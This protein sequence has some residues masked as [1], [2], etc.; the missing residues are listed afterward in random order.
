MRD[1]TASEDNQNQN[2]QITKPKVHDIVEIVRGKLI[3]LSIF[4][5][6]LKAESNQA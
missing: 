2:N 5:C 1:I 4:H 6:N 3:T